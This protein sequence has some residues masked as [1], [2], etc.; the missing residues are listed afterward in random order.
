ME[1]EER[2]KNYDQDYQDSDETLVRVKNKF[3]KVVVNKKNYYEVDCIGKGATSD[4]FLVT[5]RTTKNFAMKKIRK[6]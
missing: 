6:I 4:I 3:Q 5:N 2:K 1:I